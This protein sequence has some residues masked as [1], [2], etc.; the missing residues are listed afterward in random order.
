[1]IRKQTR[2]NYRQAECI[3]LYGYGSG[4]TGGQDF[5]GSLCPVARKCWKRTAKKALVSNPPSLVL[6]YQELINR[7]LRRGGSAQK[8][9]RLATRALAA[10]GEMS[11]Y[12]ATVSRNTQ[13]GYEDA[14]EWTR[15][16]KGGVWFWMDGVVIQHL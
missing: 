15:K 7:V 11:P 3:G 12:V 6:R 5:C 4:R 8:A 1:M 14:P 2:L 13:R 16:Y 10:K 9:E